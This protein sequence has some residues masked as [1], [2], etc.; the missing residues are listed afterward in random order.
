MA[1]KIDKYRY[2]FQENDITIAAEEHTLIQLA[3]ALREAYVEGTLSDLAYQI[4]SFFGVD[5]I[6]GTKA[7]DET[8]CDYGDCPF[9]AVSSE[10]CRYYCGLGVDESGYDEDL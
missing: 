4:E 8:P 10:D 6:N 1:Q 2:S 5:D 7:S 9:D 3:Q